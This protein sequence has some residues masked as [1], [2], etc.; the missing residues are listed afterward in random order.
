MK[1]R[2]Q[3]AAANLFTTDMYVLE[4]VK[5]LQRNSGTL[6]EL[7]SAFKEQH[8]DVANQM[9]AVNLDIAVVSSIAAKRVVNRVLQLRTQHAGALLAAVR[10]INRL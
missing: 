3:L 6:K 9:T 10:S 5:E 2:Y 8:S 4:L 7:V 1:N